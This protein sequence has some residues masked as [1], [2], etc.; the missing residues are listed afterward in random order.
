MTRTLNDPNADAYAI[1][2][3]GQ[4]AGIA[5]SVADGVRFAASHALYWSVDGQTFESISAA[6]RTLERLYCAQPVRRSRIGIRRAA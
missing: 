2:V 5:F 4:T 3:G 1:E 6:R